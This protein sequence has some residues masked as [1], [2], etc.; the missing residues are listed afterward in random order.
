MTQYAIGKMSHLFLVVTPP[1]GSD[2]QHLSQYAQ[3]KAA[4][5]LAYGRGR[6]E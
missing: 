4:S 5:W 3:R 2:L 1:M 6:A